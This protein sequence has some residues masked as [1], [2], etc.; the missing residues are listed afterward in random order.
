VQVFGSTKIDPNVP[1]TEALQPNLSVEEHDKEMADHYDQRI[2]TRP[3]RA[4]D[5]LPR[6]DCHLHLGDDDKAFTDLETYIGLSDSSKPASL[7][8]R[9]A[10]DFATV[11]ARSRHPEI[12]LYLAQRAVEKAPGSVSYLTTLG[13]AHYRAGH[14]QEA[15]ESLQSKVTPSEA[16]A[17][18]ND[19]FLLAMAHQQLGD[20]TQAKTWYQRAIRWHTKNNTDYD[21]TKRR[22]SL[23]RQSHYYGGRPYLIH[24]EA[25]ELLGTHVKK[26]DRNP[27]HTG[28]QILSV[29]A[30]VGA[31]GAT[32]VAIPAVIDGSGL[33]DG[34]EDNLLEH[35]ENTK[36]MWLSEQGQTR[37][38]VEFD[39]GG[40]YELESILVW[41]YNERGH[42]K[43]GIK[44]ADISVWTQDAGWQKIHNDFEF[45]KA[46][47]SF[48]YDEPIHVKLGGAKAQKVRFDDLANCGD[49]EHVGLSEV[50]F[51]ERRKP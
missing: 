49:D 31:E 39:L 23:R 2:S 44:K 6:A 13:A 51:F 41:N 32:A 47:G 11:T 5:Y 33:A 16:N 26:F 40:V 38:W 22:Y 24:A 21:A 4:G 34:D 12:A 19:F 27:P 42:T 8:N 48:D 18:A 9:L 25:A 3:Q 50:R 28:A 14:W 46:E 35:D 29:T 7:Y 37:G 17:N 15:A 10:W 1:L 36:N 43:R 30:T 20:R 45:A